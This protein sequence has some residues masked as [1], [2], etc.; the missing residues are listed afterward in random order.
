MPWRWAHTA[1]NSGGDPTLASDTREGARGNGNSKGGPALA[2]DV[3]RGN[4][5]NDDV[6]GAPALGKVTLYWM[7]IVAGVAADDAKCCHKQGI[8]KRRRPRH[9]AELR[10]DGG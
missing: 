10:Q 2:T 8:N 6:W 9:Q 1:G 3:R 7:E 5:G 4:N